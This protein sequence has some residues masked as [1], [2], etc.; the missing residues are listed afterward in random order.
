MEKQ[1]SQKS[2]AYVEKWEKFCSET[3][4]DDQFLESRSTTQRIEIMCAFAAAIRRNH[5]GKTSKEVLLGE[6]VKDTI[7]HVRQNFRIHGFCDPGID[8]SGNTAL[9]LSRTLNGYKK[10]DPNVENQNAISLIIFK[11][12]YFNR[13]AIKN[14]HMGMLAVGALFFGMR[15]CEYLGVKNAHEKQ[16]R[17]LEIRNL[18]FFKDNNQINKQSPE[19]RNADFV[20]ITFESQKNGEKHQTIVQH[21]LNR[22]LCPVKAWSKLAQTILAYDNTN[23]NTPVNYY[24]TDDGPNFVQASDMI[25]HLRATC[26][27]LRAA[28]VGFRPT[29]S[30]HTLYKQASQCSFTSPEC[31]ILQL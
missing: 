25:T 18:Q 31:E 26:Q 21:K 29:R 30:T 4:I 11:R 14:L 5:F 10:Q 6:S 20:A 28:R 27:T 1:S 9:K 17:L 24:Q 15:S 3:G 2:I 23:E 22:T 8:D 16:T 13:L 12:L 19:I 7:R